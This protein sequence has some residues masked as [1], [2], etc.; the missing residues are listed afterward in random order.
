[1][2]SLSLCIRQRLVAGKITWLRYFLSLLRNKDTKV[3]KK[4]WIVDIILLYI[5]LLLLL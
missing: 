1:M 4:I 2:D 5:L 3:K